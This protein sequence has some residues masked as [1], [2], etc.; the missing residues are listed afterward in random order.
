MS[1]T[2]E[3]ERPPSQYLDRLKAVAMS[4]VTGF[5]N[6]IYRLYRNCNRFLRG[7][8]EDPPKHDPCSHLGLTKSC[9]LSSSTYLSEH[10]PV[11]IMLGLAHDNHL[12]RA[13][14]SR[15]DDEFLQVGGHQT[16]I[17]HKL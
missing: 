9:R 7:L 12:M 4:P 15:N 1:I 8:E 13:I 16:K 14:A 3:R 6:S 11:F 10:N 17:Y 2:G 5:A